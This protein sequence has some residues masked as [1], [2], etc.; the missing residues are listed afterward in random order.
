MYSPSSLNPCRDEKAFEHTNVFP[1]PEADCGDE[2]PGTARAALQPK[3]KA[4]SAAGK[5]P[6]GTHRRLSDPW[7]QSHGHKPWQG[8][9]P[10]I[11]GQLGSP[12][13]N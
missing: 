13:E 6:V 2:A 3:A 11:L 12:P 7:G 10:R 8:N 4:G 5:T 9:D 1:K